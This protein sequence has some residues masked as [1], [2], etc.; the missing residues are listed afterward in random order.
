MMAGLPAPELCG[1]EVP[2][3]S[4]ASPSQSL[5]QSDPSGS[6][7]ATAR[8][9]NRPAKQRQSQRLKF[10]FSCGWNCSCPSPQKNT[11]VGSAKSEGIAESVIDLRV[12]AGADQI[13]FAEWINGLDCRSGRQPA[14]AQ[15]HGANGGFDRARPSQQMADTCVRRTDPPA[16]PRRSR[17]LT[18]CARL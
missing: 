2:T 8:F 5:A 4:L 3:A 18:D 9:P 14:F 1:R 7:S 16:A 13:E 15:R 10:D 11:R 6:R 17:P 12:G